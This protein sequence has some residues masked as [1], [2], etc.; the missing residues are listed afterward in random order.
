MPLELPPVVA[1]I[2]AAVTS[3]FEAYPFLLDPAFLFAFIEATVVFVL[4]VVIV[5]HFFSVATGYTFARANKIVWRF[6][7]KRL[8]EIDRRFRRRFHRAGFPDATYFRSRELALMSWALCT[9]ALL[10]K[11]STTSAIVFLL[12]G[13]LFVAALNSVQGWEARNKRRG[14]GTLPKFVKVYYLPTVFL[15]MPYFAIGK[16]IGYMNS[17]LAESRLISMAPF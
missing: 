6:V 9:L 10:A 16:L 13:T 5:C 4:W 8:N 7:R 3:T 12:S 2:L 15:V 17:P 1:N 14:R 11:P